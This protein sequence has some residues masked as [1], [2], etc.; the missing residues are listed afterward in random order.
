MNNKKILFITQEIDPFLPD[1]T[2]LSKFSKN[3]SE[4]VLGAG[5]D[6]RV[7][8]P[9]YGV[10]NE[11]RN[12]LHD[13]IRLS[14]SNITV[15]DIDHPLLVKV[16]SI[17]DSHMQVYFVDNDEF[18]KQKSMFKE[19]P[20]YKYSNLERSVFFI[21]GAFEAI[22]K[23][24]W[25][26]DVIH[27]MGWFAGLAPLYLRSYYKDS[28]CLGN[29]KITY[30]TM[31]GETIGQLGDHLVDILEYD[32][33]PGDLYASLR[34]E[35]SLESIRKN[36]LENAD[37]LF[38]LQDEEG[39]LVNYCQYA[40]KLQKPIRLIAKDEAV[41]GQKHGEFYNSLF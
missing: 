35:V 39:D 17:P 21:R 7:F 23:L 30:T 10:I 24:R 41:E 22:Q 31:T 5:L 3:I 12:Q 33:I 38:L 2:A 36:A 27:C 16:A 26:P 28:P 15:R 1:S 25:I 32:K 8:T 37:G 34:E 11:R 18:F 13:V 6:L 4:A 14:G 40:E 9:C 20:K 29:A 19:D